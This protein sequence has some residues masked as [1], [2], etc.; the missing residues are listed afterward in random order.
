MYLATCVVYATI[1]GRSPSGSTYTPAG[2]T[3]EEAAFLQKIA[4]QTV[5][6]YKAGRI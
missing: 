3:A 5:Q 6:E 2:V 4:W 1:Y